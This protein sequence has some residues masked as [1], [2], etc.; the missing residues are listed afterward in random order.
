MNLNFFESYPNSRLRRNRS[1]NWLRD[2]I[3]QHNLT[4]NDLILPIFISS[5]TKQKFEIKNLPNIYRYSIDYA[6]D[7]IQEAYDNGIK[8]VM[9]FPYID[10]K[11]KCEKGLEALNANNIMCKA[12]AKIKSKVP[13]IGIISDVALDPYTIHGHD[14]IIN[15]NNNVLN[16][17][18]I[19]ILCKQAIIQ[20]RAGS[21]IIA[22]SDMMDGRVAAIRKTLDENHYKDVCIMSYSI[23]FASNFYGPFRSAI[24]SDINSKI[25]KRGYQLDFRN[26]KE[27]I[28]EI[29]HDI[30]EGAD[31]III[32]PAMPY[33][34][35]IKEASMTFNHPII[36][37]QV[38]G[39]YAM[40]KNAANCNILN[41]EPAIIESLISFKR[42]GCSAIICYDSV[43][44]AKLLNK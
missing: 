33:L 25:D 29:A 4:I 31:S 7:H 34:D 40:I 14:G 42:A 26:S 39:E 9:L 21:D 13:N 20:A 12:I 41:Y 37:Y 38:S 10:S 27:A 22:P 1:Q 18:T 3:A 36:A 28:N 35:V 44:I 43:N 16:D 32:K 30:Q 2:L 19:E 11:L 24:G 17:E 15:N 8:A 5:G 6:I 23:K